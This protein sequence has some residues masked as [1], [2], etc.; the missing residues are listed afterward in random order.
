MIKLSKVTI[1]QG[2]NQRI[3]S[4]ANELKSIVKKITC[5]QTRQFKIQLNRLSDEDIKIHTKR[6]DSVLH[7]HRENPKP[8]RDANINTLDTPEYT[9]Q[10]KNL[11][12]K[13]YADTNTSDTPIERQNT[14]KRMKNDLAQ[15]KGT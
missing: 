3:L 7:V 1:T 4:D 6:T 5:I 9:K 10:R 14:P 8:E 2:A 12:R 15:I 13:H 11:K